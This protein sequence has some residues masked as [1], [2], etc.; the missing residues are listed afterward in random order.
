MASQKQE[1][2]DRDDLR[3]VVEELCERMKRV[4]EHLG[5]EV[6][7]AVE[8]RE[9]PVT[10][11]PAAA[12]ARETE[13]LEFEL[14][15]NW[16]ALIGIVVLAIGMAFVLSLPFSG[17]PPAVPSIGGAL[18]SLIVFGIAR[19]ARRSFDAIA[20]YL[21]G[22]GMLLLFFSA[23]R[24]FYFGD[25]PALE[26]GSFAGRGILLAV[27][28]INLVMA[29]RRASLNLYILALVIGFAAAVAI[30]STIFLLSL[31]TVMV[32]AAGFAQVRMEWRMLGP[33][34]FLLATASY[35]IWA[36][37]NPLAGGTLAIHAEAYAAVYVILLWIL[38]LTITVMLRPDL[39]KE[40]T[41]VQVSGVFLCGF[42]FG[43]F[44]LHNLFA[45][46]AAFIASHLAASG[47][48]LALS[49]VFWKRERSWFSTFLYAMTGYA[50]LSFALIK[51]FG[52]PEV[53]VALS[54]QSLVVIATA[55]YFCSRFIIVTNCLIFIGIILGY[56]ALAKVEQGM[57]IGFGIVALVSARV[58]NLNKDHLELKTDLMRNTYLVI[59]FFSFPYALY[60]LLPE[61]YVVVA[62]AGVA[63]LYYAMNM[64]IR[65]RKYRWM[66]HLTLLLTAF[67]V[68]IIGAGRLDS[69]YRILSFLV[70]GS[71]MLV[72]SLVFTIS[73]AKRKSREVKE[74]EA[75][76]D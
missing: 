62:W 52:I 49:L 21:R 7:E 75:E 29:W 32:L 16:F 44:F 6:Q 8:V 19:V 20:K 4:E 57:S 58:M 53:F 9:D 35:V 24:L 33:V 42:G 61:V 72:V 14:G 54:L 38:C 40:D 45:F 55:I 71:I 59:A 37:G 76:C 66:G 73:R 10:P 15:Q 2:P 26:T 65:N 12:S 27:V 1:T 69:K 68:I 64:I 11:A 43:T 23:L 28:A 5:M 39:A 30:D 22:A 3:A 50:A 25:P 51:A 63:L 46:D 70:L 74:R 60:Y 67:Y 18:L 31:A 48:F 41:P 13:S 17:L 47:V 34:V 36:I 56:L